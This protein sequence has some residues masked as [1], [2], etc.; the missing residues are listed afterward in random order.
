MADDWTSKREQTNLY[1]LTLLW[2][3]TRILGRTVTRACIIS[4]VTLV[5]FCRDRSARHA[6]RVF[7]HRINGVPPSLWL[8]F[9]HFYTFATVTLDRTFILS[10][11][12]DK[13]NVS[14]HGEEHFENLDQGA[15]V[16]TAHYGCFEIARVLGQRTRGLTIDI[17]LDKQH[18]PDTMRFL[19]HLNPAMADRIVDAA[20][21][22]PQL[23]LKLAHLLD[24]NHLVGIMAD[25][26]MTGQRT[27]EHTFLG[28]DARFPYGPWAMAI[29]LKRPV[30]FCFGT[31]NGGNRYTITCERLDPGSL[32]GTTQQRAEQAVTHYVSALERH[33]RQYPLNWFNF[34]DFWSTA[35]PADTT[36]R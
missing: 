20:T 16:V 19:R 35:D 33:V 2:W 21:P 4:M 12:L 14:V 34:Y 28:A 31:F 3:T 6:S 22:G 25:R 1:W 26:V 30:I 9:K 24:E 13:F 11:M 15:I 27:I 8:I 29:I 5:Y 10:G 36:E 17:L 23:V 7:L 18:N 32:E